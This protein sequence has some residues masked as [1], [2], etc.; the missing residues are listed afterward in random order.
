MHARIVSERIGNR[1]R[2]WP[3]LLALA[4]VVSLIV[5]ATA[6]PAAMAEGAGM[7]VVRSDS[8]G[9]VVE[10]ETPDYVVEEQEVHG[11]ACARIAVAGYDQGGLPGKPQLPVQVA[12]LGVPPSAELELE[13]RPLETMALPKRLGICPAPKPVVEEDGGLVRYVEREAQPDPDV[14]GRDAFFPLASA[15][16]EEVGFARDQ[17]IVR[18]VMYPFQVNPVSGETL[19]HRRLSV[20][21]HF[22]GEAEAAAAVANPGAFDA[23]L[24]GALLNYDAARAWRGAPAQGAAVAAPWL[25][26]DP[27]YKVLIRQEGLY[28]IGRSV[29]AAAGLPVAALDPR[30]LKMYYGGQEMAI[31]VS[32]EE[33]GRLDEADLL[34]FYGQ[35]VDTRY[36][37]TNVYWLTYGGDEGRRMTSKSGRV[38]GARS[39]TYTAAAHMEKD[40]FYVS[41]VPMAEGHDHWYEYPALGNGEAWKPAP[42]RDYAFAVEHLAPGSQAARLEVAIGG[43][44][45]GAHHL[46]FLINGQQVQDTT[47]RRRT[48][49]QGS[50]EFP[51][52]LLTEGANTLRIEVVND[53][54]GQAMDSVY[55]DWLRV[56]YQRSYTAQGDA[57]AF[58]AD[59]AG[60]WHYIVGGFSGQAVELYDVTDPV[61]VRQISDARMTMFDQLVFLPLVQRNRTATTGAAPGAALQAAAAE[62]EY[63]LV[64]GDA[65]GG[66]RR[67]VVLSPDQRRAVAAADIAPVTKL[68]SPYTPTDL[69]SA[70]NGADYLIVSHRDFW[71]EAQT[72]AAHRSADFRVAL[73][74]VQAVYDQFGYG[75]MSAEAI[76]DFV[77]YAYLHWSGEALG[78]VVLLGDGTYDMRQRLA[79]AASGPTY[80]PPFLAMVD[81]ELGETA[82]DNR[83]ATVIGSDL[84]PDLH[85]GRLP[86]NTPAEAGVMIQKILTYEGAALRGAADWR[87]RLL[88][89]A[90]DTEGGGGDFHALSD[91][92][93]DGYADPPANTTK[94]VPAGYTKTKVYLALS[95]PSPATARRQQVLNAINAGTLLISYVGHATKSFWAAER[96][97]DQTALLTLNNAD[98]LPITL[99]MTCYDGYFHEPKA[100]AEVIGETNMRMAGGGSVATW[101]A[102]GLGLAPG[103]DF[104]ERGFFLAVFHAP[105]S[106]RLGAAA[107]RGKLHLS[108][109]DPDG[110]YKDL[111]DTFVLLGD[112]GLR[113]VLA[114]P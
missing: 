107:T 91:A 55:V 105:V 109:H 98:R 114:E 65:E 21:I 33:D 85:V 93:A 92:I 94:L 35:G 41:A 19:Y 61:N 32:G 52:S 38:V 22:H 16:L 25:P 90:D 18:V 17:R 56:S 42:P 74:D 15:R 13:V 40:N 24:E 49:Y 110:I 54:A 46:R 27:A 77:A 101:S 66:V 20:A 53:T 78:Y 103:H 5:P 36:T 7:R 59:R 4:L 76:R 12:L 71:A 62:G 1:A 79:M 23:V 6:A 86:A 87:Q 108:A 75:L 70:G 47:W 99:A 106:D 89:V 83:Y 2:P 14:Y 69:G 57:L 30:T 43:N 50:A 64:F 84:V 63:S 111:M 11:E 51:Q 58:G 67:Y 80:I 112:P 3:P 45:D 102:T 73:V 39:T 44:V 72:L 10:L 37:G 82:A 96:L 104:L 28:Q 9:L 48:L 68:S 81:P 34:L 88:F 113:I 97:M 60:P 31:V 100:G 29:L 26:P 8:E 95:D